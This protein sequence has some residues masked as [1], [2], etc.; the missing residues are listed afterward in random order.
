MYMEKSRRI[1]SRSVTNRT[2]AILVVDFDRKLACP[3]QRF[4]TRH[5]VTCSSHCPHAPTLLLLLLHRFALADLHG[6]RIVLQSC[7]RLLSLY[8]PVV[9]HHRTAACA[10]IPPCSFPSSI[11]STVDLVSS[12]A[13]ALELTGYK[14]PANRAS[15][16][17]VGFPGPVR[18]AFS[19]SALGAVGQQHYKNS[20]CHPARSGLPLLPSFLALSL[21]P[22]RSALKATAALLSRLADTLWSFV[23]SLYITPGSPTVTTALD[24]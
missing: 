6:V 24:T 21:L 19:A 10:A 16:S 4:E 14:P 23:S 17:H 1:C 11:S 9:W 5:L 7:F 22:S 18:R 20:F 15:H 3:L 13:P 12:G 2:P 8:L